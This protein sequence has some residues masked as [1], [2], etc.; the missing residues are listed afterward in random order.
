M[1]AHLP[2]WEREKLLTEKDKDAIHRAIHTRW[3]DIDTE[4]AETEAG[5]AE[6]E[7]IISQKRHLD[8]WLLGML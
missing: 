8:E 6:L 4:S 3:E 1:G 7:S 2:W 5:K